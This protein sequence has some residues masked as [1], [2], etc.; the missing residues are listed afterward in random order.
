M[1]TVYVHKTSGSMLNITCSLHSHRIGSSGKHMEHQDSVDSSTQSTQQG[2][3]SS[4]NYLT[5]YNHPHPFPISAPSSASVSSSHPNMA[6]RLS[7]ASNVTTGSGTEEHGGGNGNGG[8]GE[9]GDQPHDPKPLKVSII[10]THVFRFCA[11]F[12]SPKQC[13]TCAQGTQMGLE[14]TAL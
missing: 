2:G 8:S 13:T 1:Y 3:G 14:P 11:V 5:P 12:A 6:R 9:N 10:Y 7:S 4:S